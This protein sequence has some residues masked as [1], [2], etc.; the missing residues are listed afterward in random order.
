MKIDKENTE[1]RK[2]EIDLKSDIEN[3]NISFENEVSKYV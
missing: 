1:L 3:M 2:K